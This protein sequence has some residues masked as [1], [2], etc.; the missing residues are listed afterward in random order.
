MLSNHYISKDVFAGY[1]AEESVK[2]ANKKL[3]KFDLQI[4]KNLDTV[5]SITSN[6]PVSSNS[7][8]QGYAKINQTLKNN[9]DGRFIY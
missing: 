4:R 2:R 1:T 3:D 5:D 6:V 8:Y 9:A 7:L